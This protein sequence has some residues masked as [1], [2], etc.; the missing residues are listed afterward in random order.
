MAP[1]RGNYKNGINSTAV[2]G[3]EELLER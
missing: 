1:Y 3:K 2:M